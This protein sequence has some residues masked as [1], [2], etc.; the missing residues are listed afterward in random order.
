MFYIGSIFVILLINN[1]VLLQVFTIVF[2]HKSN[3]NYSLKTLMPRSVCHQN[4][5]ET[6]INQYYINLP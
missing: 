1:I 2:D 5:N 6:N 3:E 4:Q